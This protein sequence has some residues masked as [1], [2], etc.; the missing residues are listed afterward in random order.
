MHRR[1]MLRTGLLALGSVAGASRADTFPTR[2]MTLLVPYAVGGNADIT[3]RLY[4]EALSRAVGQTVV[5]ENK[6]GAGG[7]IGALQVI[8]GRADGHTLLFSAPS[9]F[10]VTPHL[11]KVSYT[12]SS[13]KPVCVVSKTPLVLVAR[14]GSPYRS[15][16]ALIEGA[17]SRP[18][19]VPMGYSGLGTPNHLA[20]LN[21]ETVGQVR[22]NPIAYKGSGPMLQDMLAGQIEVGADQITTSKPY[23]DSGDLIPLA[24]FGAA[25]PLLPG[26]PSVSMLGPEPVDVTTYLGLA[27]PQGIADS[28]LAALQK[29]TQS[30]AQDARFSSEITRLGSV[31]SWG[32]GQEYERLIRSENDFIRSMVAAGRIKP[33]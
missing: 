24:V 3:A 32:G 15:L 5:V 23:I 27:A 26:I 18:N 8:G 2:P 33:D 1:T 22:F 19:A 17:R 28:T 14:K 13:I 11:I 30:A 31:V 7:S 6:A 21:L 25:L 12:L 16:A 9:V 10:S 29:A 4:A 20:L